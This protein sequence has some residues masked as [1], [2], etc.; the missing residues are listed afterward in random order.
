MELLTMWTIYDH[1]IDFPNGFVAREWVIP[2]DGPPR[3][4]GKP[5]TADSLDLVRAALPPDLYC[6]GRSDPDD[7]VIVETWI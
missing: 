1:P 7:S 3:P 2:K 6:L 4:V 5:I